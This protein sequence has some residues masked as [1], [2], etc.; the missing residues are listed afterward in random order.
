M[1]QSPPKL[2]VT[3]GATLTRNAKPQCEAATLIAFQRTVRHKE[4][5]CTIVPNAPWGITRST[6]LQIRRI[7]KY[8][9]C[10]ILGGQA[11]K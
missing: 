4:W 7:A 6:E 8:G 10:G 2:D 5:N 9:S 1:R 11:A 3:S